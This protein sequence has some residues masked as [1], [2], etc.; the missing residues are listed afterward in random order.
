MNWNQN[1]K[2]NRA[3]C[4]R[5]LKLL[6]IICKIGTNSATTR[7]P[8]YEYIFFIEVLVVYVA[9]SNGKIQFMWRVHEQEYHFYKRFLKS[10]TNV[11]IIQVSKQV[12]IFGFCVNFWLH[13][14]GHGFFSLLAS[15]Y[16]DGFCIYLWWFSHQMKFYAK[17]HQHC[18]Y[19]GMQLWIIRKFLD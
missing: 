2:K 19:M 5:Q 18:R 6:P 3:P 1:E 16:R 15:I 14:V 4:V 7:N 11:S 8:I 12:I 17:Y 10:M 13:L 9:Q